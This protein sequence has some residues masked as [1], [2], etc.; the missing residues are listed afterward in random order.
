MLYEIMNIGSI[1]ISQQNLVAIILA[2]GL[3]AAMLIYT[4]RI[5]WLGTEGAGRGELTRGSVGSEEGLARSSD[6]YK[7]YN[8]EMVNNRYNPSRVD[9]ELGD[10]VVL[11]FTNN[12]QVAHGVGLPAF[13]AEI[14]GGHVKPGETARLEFIANKQVSAD[15]ATCGGPNPSDKT[16]D[17]GEELVVNV[18]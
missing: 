16:D 5:P 7:E 6:G 13:N 2:G 1:E 3:I 12:D 9:V 14:P 18:V 15:A 8:I 17:H 11:N 4:G 10:R